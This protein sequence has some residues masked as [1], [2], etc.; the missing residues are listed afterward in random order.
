MS[1]AKRIGSPKRVGI[2]NTRVMMSSRPRLGTLALTVQKQRQNKEMKNSMS[3]RREWIN[4]VATIQWG[5]SE[6]ERRTAAAFFFLPPSI[7]LH[8]LTHLTMKSVFFVSLLS[9]GWDKLWT[10]SQHC[11]NVRKM[12][13][14]T[15]VVGVN[16]FFSNAIINTILQCK[17]LIWF[18][19]Q[20]KQPL[21][22]TKQ[23]RKR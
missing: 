20:V 2:V 6:D 12:L 13:Q 16:F 8:F 19:A 14:W 5:A 17:Y 22:D 21:Y 11:F 4:S 15:I 9:L 10:S 3:W 18:L 1:R 7:V 23:T